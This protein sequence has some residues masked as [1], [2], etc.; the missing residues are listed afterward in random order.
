MGGVVAA[1]LFPSD[2]EH[3]TLKFK[4]KEETLS[5]LEADEEKYL[6]HS[7]NYLKRN[8]MNKAIFYLWSELPPV[9]LSQQSELFNFFF[10]LWSTSSFK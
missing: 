1:H 5:I 8:E 2:A 6:D 9:D 4:E 10:N 3:P 7:V